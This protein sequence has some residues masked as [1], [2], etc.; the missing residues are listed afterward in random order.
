MARGALSLALFGALLAF[1]TVLIDV[2]EGRK[3]ANRPSSAAAA[4]SAAGGVPSTGIGEQ[5]AL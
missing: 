5:N 3:R 4:Q 2:A 1:A